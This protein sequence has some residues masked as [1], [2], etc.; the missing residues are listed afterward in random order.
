MRPETRAY[1]LVN[2]LLLLFVV[3]ALAGCTF[4][5]D[6]VTDPTGRITIPRQ[7]FINTHAFLAVLTEDLLAD[8][9]RACE[10]KRWP[11]SNCAR[12]PAIK[13]ELRVL[14]LSIRAKIAVPE[15]EIDWAVV[16]G[17][18]KALAGLRP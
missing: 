3:V 4:A 2:L 11:E 9:E 12:L 15:S 18:L 5:H 17:I 6:L 7:E 10:E 14:D 8:A 1:L 16:L 13:H